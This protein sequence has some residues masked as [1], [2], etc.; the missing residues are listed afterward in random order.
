V[1]D[2]VEYLRG[3]G[4]TAASIG[5]CTEAEA[6]LIEK[7]KIA[8]VFG[9]PEDWIQSERWGRML[10]NSVYSKKLCALAIDEADVI[11]QR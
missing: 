6:T 3:K 11:R 10:G 5:S 8:V 2:Q 7:G 9:S 1:N 4:V